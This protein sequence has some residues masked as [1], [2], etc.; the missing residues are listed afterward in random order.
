VI[1]NV[2]HRT[3]N[4]G[5][6]LIFSNIYGRLFF[7]TLLYCD[8]DAGDE[9]AYSYGKSHTQTDNKRGSVVRRV[10]SRGKDRSGFDG[11]AKDVLVV[12]DRI[13]DQGTGGGGA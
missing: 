6:G 2:V 13:A 4:L 1:L 3:I 7:L 8:E 12:V 5:G 10:F 9:K 11:E